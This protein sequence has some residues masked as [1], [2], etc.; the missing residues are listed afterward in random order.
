MVMAFFKRLSSPSNELEMKSIEYRGGVVTFRIPAHWKEEYSDTEGGMFYGR[1]SRSGTLRLS[2]VT[3]AKP[4]QAGPTS[5]LDVLEVIVNG[6]K[7]NGVMG[8]TKERKDGNGLFKYEE[9]ASERGRRITIFYCILVN[10]VQP[11]HARVATF[12]YTIVASE[13]DKSQVQRELAMLDAEIQ[14]ASFSPQLGIVA[15]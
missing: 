4:M 9:A 13:R 10:P 6:L 15:E 5:A 8:I 1:S 2:I 11:Y 3:V 7:N 14:G 12:S